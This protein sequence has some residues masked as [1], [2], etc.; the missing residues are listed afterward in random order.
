ME[1]APTN[2]N[3]SKKPELYATVEAPGRF[4]ENIQRLFQEHANS[5]I[6]KGKIPELV[7]PHQPAG[8][9]ALIRWNVEDIIGTGAKLTKYY[10]EHYTDEISED[11]PDVRFFVTKSNNGALSII[12][13]KHVDASRA[14]Y[15]R[16]QMNI[17][18]E[19]AFE[20]LERADSGIFDKVR[21]AAFDRQFRFTVGSYILSDY[22]IE[23]SPSPLDIEVVSKLVDNF[24]YRIGALEASTS[25]KA[26]RKRGDKYP[27][28]A[29]SEIVDD[30][31]SNMPRASR[32]NH[33]TPVDLLGATDDVATRMNRK[34]YK[35]IP[36]ID[37]NATRAKYALLGFK[38]SDKPP[39]N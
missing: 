2:N 6:M 4:V 23:G 39:T 13:V 5:V 24:N 38:L 35:P 21:D 3:E 37:Q 15:S 25:S 8:E 18:A 27:Q 30:A 34:W 20:I 11:Q 26:K 32:V 14:S 12:N 17:S 36:A 9:K 7:L 33:F 29:Y 1:G 31:I 22:A 28:P 19:E 16:K 10:M